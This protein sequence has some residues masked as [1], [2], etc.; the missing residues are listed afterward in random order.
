MNE[1]SL[2]PLLDTLPVGLAWQRGGELVWAN[3]VARALLE[4]DDSTVSRACRD[5]LQEDSK[6]DGGEVL[7]VRGQSYAVGVYR[8]EQDALLM[9][10]PYGDG[11]RVFPGLDR[12]RQSALDFEEIFRNS[13]D[14]IFVAD[15]A[16]MTLM[17]NE[18]CERNY[19]LSAAD[20]IG[21][22]VSEFE[23]AGWIRPVVAA[24]V[25]R[26]G[27]RISTTQH[28]HTG[29]TIL[30]TGIPLIDMAGNV[31]K[32]IINSRDMTELRQL[33]DTLAQTREKLRKVDEEN[34][35]LRL[36]NLR[37]E[38]VVV[39]SEPMRRV[40]ELAMR[41][42]RVDATV[43]ITGPSGVGKDV[44]ASMIHGESLRSAGPFIKINCG[45]LPHDL[46]ESELFGYEPGAFT[47]AQRTGKSG[48]VELANKG[49]LFLDEIGDMPLGL[50]VKLLQM[51]QDRTVVR[52]GGTRAMAVD[53]R[54]I[55]A[56]NRD[57]KGMVEARTFRD[58]LYYR[59]N[60]IPIQ[61]PSLADRKDDVAPMVHQFVEEFNDR[62]GCRRTMSEQAMA[63]LIA[64]DW[65]GNVRE[66]RNVVERL[67]VTCETDVISP[68]FLD[69]VLPREVL[70]AQPNSF[71]QRVGRFERRLVEDA[72]RQVGNTRDAARL[73]GLSQSSVVRKL[74][75]GT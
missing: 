34:E 25:A 65:P 30:V 46:L 11:T 58:D 35:A 21:R 57:L 74:R 12:L 7:V 32:V 22:H 48:L 41:V 26:T 14:G 66:L 13:F 39:R 52:I 2:A 68:E 8:R 23:K 43:L 5:A 16:G 17:V 1:H 40:A 24:Q 54:V 19:D 4:T 49:T 31:R 9:L 3:A 27:L 42:A 62:Y 29:K 56:T 75:G 37:V 10:V 6:A 72:M 28:T 53:V 61:V 59:L 69:G 36:Q 38:H 55:A 73:L 67:I 44:I 45:A 64:Y 63:L 15:G 70:D 71:R 47:G 50:Q 18:G 60:V 20:M 51:L 33:Q